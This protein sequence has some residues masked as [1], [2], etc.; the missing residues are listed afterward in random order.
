MLQQGQQLSQLFHYNQTVSFIEDQE[1]EDNGQ[2]YNVLI[3]DDNTLGAK[4]VYIPLKVTAFEAN[5][6][7]ILNLNLVTSKTNTGGKGISSAVI[8]VGG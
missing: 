1:D 5:K 3:A 8:S 6:N 4:S 7:Y 2:K